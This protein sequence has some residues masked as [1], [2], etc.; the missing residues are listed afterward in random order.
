MFRLKGSLLA[1]CMLISVFV[2]AQEPLTLG[3]AEDLAVER[4]LL[5]HGFV[6][7]ADAFRA[8]A[9]ARGQLPDPML[10]IGVENLPTDSY[11]L[12]KEPM[13]KVSV[14]LSQQFP[15]GNTRTLRSEQSLAQAGGEEARAAEQRL[16]TLRGVRRAWFEVWYQNQALETVR[17]SKGLFRRLVEI[18]EAQYAAGRDNQQVVLE[19]RVELARLAD[20]ESAVQ[21]ELERARAGLVRWIGNEGMRP[22]PLT[23]AQVPTVADLSRL[24][25]QLA[26]HPV[27]GA[28]VAEILVSEKEMQLAHQDYRPAFALDLSYGKR[29]GVQNGEPRSD[30]VTAMIQMELPLFTGKRQ[31]QRVAAS[32]QRADAVRYARDDRLREL[33]AELQAAYASWQRLEQRLEGYRRE[34]L[35]PSALNA[36]AADRAYRHRTVE[37][38]TLVRARLSELQ[39]R[40]EALRIESDR[41]R[42]QADLDYFQPA[43]DG[44]I[45]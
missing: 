40:L 3:A 1:G 22:V 11:A 9:V 8:E 12:D 27:I 34:V 4:D 23:A 7:R 35:P 20:R 25:A 16:R 14:G 39:A 45:R 17:A 43:N 28:D 15:R 21:A 41:A 32:R 42:A 30:M 10:R 36:I 26:D 33:R 38:G 2:Q 29:F 13:T 31:D 44:E 6:A 5:A 24:E 19:A 37:F 18:T